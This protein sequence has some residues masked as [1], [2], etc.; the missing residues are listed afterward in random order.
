MTWTEIERDERLYWAKVLK[1]MDS[2]KR[3]DFLNNLPV[4]DRAQKIVDLE[5]FK[6]YGVI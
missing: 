3:E 6:K 1:K 4:W 5:N 2:D